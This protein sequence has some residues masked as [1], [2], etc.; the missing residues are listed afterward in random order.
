M[1]AEAFVQVVT[2]AAL[3]AI[4][5]YYVPL[6]PRMAGN[7]RKSVRRFIDTAITWDG[8]GVEANDG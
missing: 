4:A 2:L 8:P 6:A 3:T 7:F 1:Q 5:A